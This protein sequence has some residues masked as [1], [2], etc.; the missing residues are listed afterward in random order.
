MTAR[1][2]AAAKSSRAVVSGV[3]CD[4][5]DSPWPL[6]TLTYHTECCRRSHP[7]AERLNSGHPCTQALLTA[8]YGHLWTQGDSHHQFSD[9]HVLQFRSPV[10]GGEM[11]DGCLLTAPSE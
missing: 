3:D 10:A 8:N 1:R 9:T 7:H 11:P 4:L 6:T 2:C 5:L